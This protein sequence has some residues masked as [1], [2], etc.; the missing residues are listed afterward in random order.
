MNF[1][2]RQS[3]VTAVQRYFSIPA[4]DAATVVG[5]LEPFVCRGGDWLFRQG[6]PADGLFLLARGRLQV[7]MEPVGV[8]EG[9]PRLVAEVEPGETVGEIGMLT[10]GTRSASLR[11]VRNSL[12]LKMS[13]GDFDR[14][15]RQRPELMRHVA[16]GIATR[17]RDRTA[18]ATSI[19]RTFKTVALLPLDADPSVLAL[20]EGLRGALAQHGSTLVLS[21]QGLREI[22]APALPAAAHEDISPAMV[23]WLAKQEDEHRFVL[24]VADPTE[25]AWSDLAVRHADL[26]LLVARSAGDAALRPWE[27][28]LLGSPGGPVARRA[29]I[30]GHEG[31]P[32]TLTGTA[33]WLQERNLDFHVHVRSGV[34]ADLQRLARIL[35]GKALGLVLGGGA[36]RGFA[37]LGVYRALC[38]AGTPVDWLGGS[39]IGA[40]MGAGMAGGLEPGEVISRARTA[41]VHGKPFGD[42]TLPIV[43]FVRGRRM[44]RLIDQHLGGD[45]EDLP[46]PFFCVSSNLGQGTV[47]VHERGS[48]PQALRASVSL[49]GVFPPAVIGRQLAVDGGILD[50]LP[51]DLMR[52]R[53]VGRVV[54]VD[55]TSRRTYEVDYDAVPS[56]WAVLA[57]RFLPIT[58][59]Y[60]VPGAVSLMLMAMSIGTMAATRAAAL[61]SDL[62]IRPKVGGFSFTDVRPFDQIVEAGY[63]AAREAIAEAHVVGVTDHDRVPA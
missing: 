12:L 26:I 27:R 59:R 38:E 1:S 24:Y 41:F 23:D 63:Q 30:L 44:E 47:T 10:G 28:A 36:A 3:L 55:L 22:D 19:R 52:E 51:V 17:L 18:G 2:A 62:L 8:N 11:A 57:G 45:I 4:E 49:P 40:V 15:A 31:S 34:P 60:R 33:R 9:G 56:P 14:L 39:S 37:H 25:N 32:A 13:S 16:G 7:W 35:A 50:N 46:V 58:K 21:S 5:E 48:L 6:D 54:A 53:P 43:S 20:A 61:R 29:L 42:I